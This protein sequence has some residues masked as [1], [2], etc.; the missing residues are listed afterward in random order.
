VTLRMSG[1]R[2]WR[3]TI[4]SA[5]NGFAASWLA[6]PARLGA[7]FTFFFELPKHL[8]AAGLSVEYTAVKSMDDDEAEQKG[9][10]DIK[11]TKE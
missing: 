6:P 1:E 7:S 11:L 10:V 3:Q 9:R 5:G 2:E 8:Q 4:S